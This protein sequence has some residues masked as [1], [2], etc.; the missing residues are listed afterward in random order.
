VDATAVSVIVFTPVDDTEA[1][2]VTDAIDDTDAAV[3][4]DSRLV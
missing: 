4:N 2:G 1:E 3:V